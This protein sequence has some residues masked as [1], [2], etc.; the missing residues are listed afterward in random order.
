MLKKIPTD[1]QENVKTGLGLVS[2]QAFIILHI[3]SRLQA[4]IPDSSNSHSANWKS[5]REIKQY[6]RDSQG[7]L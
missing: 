3:F 2:R 7:F 5:P 6:T 1:Q 4:E